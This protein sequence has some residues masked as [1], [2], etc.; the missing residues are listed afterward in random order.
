MTYLSLL[1]DDRLVLFRTFPAFRMELA[2]VSDPF[3][4]VR[5]GAIEAGNSGFG[6]FVFTA[7]WQDHVV[8]TG[9]QESGEGLVVY[10]LS[11]RFALPLLTFG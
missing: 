2:D 10:D 7:A 11:R 4:P 9:F 5:K 8:I 1:N 3:H 6:G